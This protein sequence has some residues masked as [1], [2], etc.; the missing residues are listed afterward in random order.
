MS[1]SKTGEETIVSVPNTPTD[2]P[3]LRESQED[4]L[5]DRDKKVMMYTQS[6]DSPVTADPPSGES[7]EPPEEAPPPRLNLGTRLSRRKLLVKRRRWIVDV[8]FALALAGI[9]LM[10]LNTEFYINGIYT[11]VSLPSITIKMMISISTI[12]LLIAIIAN[13]VTMIQLRMIYQ[14]L[15]EWQLVMHTCDWVCLFTELIICL[16]HPLPGNVVIYYF[17]Q[18]GSPHLVSLDAI[19]SIWMMLRLYLIGKFM[20]AHSHLL[21]DTSIQSFGALSRVKINAMFVFKALMSTNPGSVLIAIMALMFVVDSWAMRTC[22][23]YYD[24]ENPF[25][26][27]PSSMWLIAITFLTVGYG[28]IVPNSYCGRFISV[29]TGLMGVGTTALLVA[30]M[31]SKLEQTRAEKYVHNFVT[32][33]QL[34]RHKRDAAADVLKS[35][36]RIWNLKKKKNKGRGRK[37]IHEQGRLFQS[38]RKMKFAKNEGARLSESAIGLVEIGRTVFWIQDTLLDMQK[39]QNDTVDKISALNE[40]LASLETKLDRAKKVES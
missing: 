16:V 37:L 21:S 23:I 9:I 29:I 6:C 3:L 10:V 28:D 7:S 5:V 32:R 39:H 36:L 24:P 11:L 26:G 1:V 40:R 8:E 30:V 18:L 12:A 19:L 27:F 14:G 22:E 13:Y 20:V 35:G 31:A 33:I 4:P 15:F 38:I 17:P 25:G 2:P 34:E